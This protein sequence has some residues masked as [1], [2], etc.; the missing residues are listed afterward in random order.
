MK[1][2]RYFASDMTTAIKLV[3]DDLGP[4]AIILSNK[5][6]PGGVE[7]ISALDGIEDILARESNS[8][9]PTIKLNHKIGRRPS[10]KIVGLSEERKKHALGGAGD[11]RKKSSLKKTGSSAGNKRDYWLAGGA[12]PAGQLKKDKEL[13]KMDA[14]SNT[15]K[16][17]A[18]EEIPDKPKN[19]FDYYH[20]V[21]T[22]LENLPDY[23]EQLPDAEAS[24]NQKNETSKQESMDSRELDEMKGEILYLRKLIE[25]QNQAQPQENLNSTESPSEYAV[26]G[27]LQEFG[28]SL[29]ICEHSLLALRGEKYLSVEGAVSGIVEGARI[30]AKDYVACAGTLALVGPAGVGKTTTIAKLAA[31]RILDRGQSSVRLISFDSDRIGSS[32]QIKA[33][34]DL[35]DIET[36]VVSER[37][38]PD[39]LA[40]NLESDQVLTL[41]DSAGMLP[42]DEYW[43]AHKN[44]LRNMPRYVKKLLVL[45]CSY[46]FNT[47]KVIIENFSN[48]ELSGCILTKLDETSSMGE[49]LSA[50]IESDLEIQY[51][52]NGQQIPFDIFLPDRN[53]ILDII[54]RQMENFGKSG[55]SADDLWQG[56][57]SRTKIRQ[58]Q[59]VGSRFRKQNSLAQ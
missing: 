30:S 21:A 17:E 19:A 3:R 8:A 4:E 46:Q 10:E 41:I 25:K 57:E 32:H 42:N 47:L 12:K 39:L 29:S 58:Q 9:K 34:G 2:K 26:F 33:I 43:Y 1:P 53:R 18:G 24:A 56:I 14:R 51:I 45:P 28:F 55:K 48:I 59:N 13:E 44:L 50:V 37:E 40:R 20:E 15:N 5:K 11:N 27:Q 6:V 16:R 38:L 31:K 7:I 23:E 35:L 54:Q 36:H 49:V 22:E 52:T